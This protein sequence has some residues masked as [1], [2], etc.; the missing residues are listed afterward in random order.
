MRAEKTAGELA[1]EEYLNERGIAFEY[2][3][4]LRFTSELIDYVIEDPY[5][6][7]QTHIQA[8]K[9]KFK[10]FTDQLCAIV[11]FAAPGT[12]NLM[13]SHV[14]LGAMYGNL[15]FTIPV[16]TE[17]G[18][19]DASRIETKS[20][21]GEGMTVRPTQH[22]NTRIAALISLVWFNTFNIEAFRYIN[23][24]DGRSPGERWDDAFS[25]RAGISQE[26]T[27]CV[28]VWENGTAK[29]RLPQ[30][31]FGGPMDAWWTLDEGSQGSTFIG[32]RRVALDIDKR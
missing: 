6:P 8:V 15:G 14:M 1:F 24:D 21:V 4:S 9:D 7:I 23:T 12:V 3:P 16:N 18:V 11:L 29:H 2:E 17:T 19:A 25:G 13:Q 27:L 31:L 5:E 26:D 20:L 32:K 28:S 22:R 10:N 30:N